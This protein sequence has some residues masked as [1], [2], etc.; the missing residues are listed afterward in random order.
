METCLCEM[1]DICKEYAA[2]S[3]LKNVDF[4]AQRGE[5]CVL[6]GKNGAGKSTLIKILAGATSPSSGEVY[7]NGQRVKDFSTKNAFNLG[8]SVLYQELRLLPNLTVKENIFAGHLP[9]RKGLLTVDYHQMRRRARQLLESLQISVDPD[10]IVADL[11]TVEK[12]L[13]SIAA[14]FSRR[15]QLF[16]FDEPS[17]ILSIKEL[18]VLYQSIQ[19]MKKMRR[20]IIYITHRMEEIPVIADRV[21]V[22]RDGQKV[23]DD[24]MENTSLE[25]LEVSITGKS[26]AKER[27]AANAVQ[28]T[29]AAPKM[30]LR[31]LSYGDVL[32][33]VNL[34]FHQN[35]VYCIYGLE[36]SGKRA[37]GKILF[38]DLQ[39]T[40]GQ[41]IIDGR[42]VQLNSPRDG[43][44][45]GIGYMVDE[46]ASEGLLLAKTIA[47]NIALPT[48][49][50]LKG[51]IFLDFSKINKLA[52]QR[53]KE[54]GIV[55]PDPDAPLGALSGGNQQKVLLGKWLEIGSILV[56][57]D[58][59]RGLDIG[60]KEKVMELIAKYKAGRT[61]ILIPSE[62]EEGLAVSDWIVIIRDGKIVK[63][64]KITSATDK[65]ELLKLAGLEF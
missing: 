18:K 46:R 49:D 60:V 48:L 55:P 24:K 53:I 8:I 23:L 33:E 13:V 6:L 2:V 56:L 57:V 32:Q 39:P 43:I 65:M 9:R 14:A 36:G 30:Q 42:A 35:L 29:D 62:I 21:V 17:A 5:T 54:L 4:Y 12:Q 27:R 51:K 40:S 63:N 26:I 20:G 3:A 7:F 47:E 28:V 41:L 37:L 11:S 61:T 44:R 19:N 15:A 52:T 59:T 38:G 45:N 50:R 16:I 1:K 58:P 25:E 10:K 64:E 31:D 22:L 34:E